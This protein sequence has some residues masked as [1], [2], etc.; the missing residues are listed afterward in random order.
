VDV[1]GCV[2]IE[3]SLNGVASA[4]ASGA[5][6]LAIEYLIPIPPGPLRTVDT[7]LESWSPSR[8]AGLLQR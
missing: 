3:D 2:A 5:A 4:E 7:T 8:L 1:T 6:V